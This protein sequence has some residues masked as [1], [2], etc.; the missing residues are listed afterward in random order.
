[1]LEVGHDLLAK[2]ALT[3][4]VEADPANATAAWQLS[5]AL[6]NL[7]ELAQA[8]VY[9]EKAVALDAD[10][11]AYHVQ[12]GAV[13]GSVAE[14]AS[15][16]KQLGLARRTRKE[17]EEAVRLDPQNIEGLYGLM[18]Y[19][20]SAPSFMGGDKNRA[21][22]LAEQI[23][24]VDEA[25]GWM[26]RAALAREQKD[27]AAQLQSGLRAVE[28]N[29][30][31]FDALSELTQYYLDR[32]QPDWALIEQNA[33]KLLEMDSGRPDGWRAMAEF[34]IASHCWT[35]LDDVLQISE[36]FNHEDLS[37]YY[38]AAAA[39]LRNEDRLDAARAYLEKYL[40]QPPDGSE[41][42]HAM[43]RWQ[44]ANLL[45]KQQHP[46][47]A[48]AQLDL[49]LQLDPGLEAAKKDLKRLRGK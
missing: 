48:A 14:K 29:P 7:G 22:K 30:K 45:E 20:Q 27:P 18:L 25:R 28:A 24:A 46:E 35:E 1:L 11:A 17:L 44:L 3:P 19:Y 42:S 13:L 31:N 39:L 12:L 37:P 38:S 32:P 33:C 36:Q 23:G 43:A 9:A 47:D 6:F 4:I 10:N 34:H 8:Q 21:T 2:A 40:S 41:P 49:A 16:F 15:I 5:K 26:A